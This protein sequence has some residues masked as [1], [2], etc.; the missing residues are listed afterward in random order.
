MN[1]FTA[2]TLSLT[3]LAS[4]DSALAFDSITETEKV[5]P[6]GGMSNDSAGWSIA[7]DGD[8]MAIGS[9]KDNTSDGGGDAGSVT[10]IDAAGNEHLL[11]ASNAGI[12]ENL[13]YSVDVRGNLLIAGA[14]LHPIATREGAA[15]IY[16]RNNNGNWVEEAQLVAPNGQWSDFFGCSVAISDTTAVVGA[17]LSDIEGPSSGTAWVF[18]YD[19]CCDWELVQ[20]LVPSSPTVKFGT[21]VAIG[22]ERIIVGSPR[23]NID[24]LS[25][26]SAYIFYLDRSDNDWEEEQRL[27]GSDTAAFDYFGYAVDLNVDGD[28]AVVGAI[29]NDAAAPNAGAAYVYRRNRSD[30]TWTEQEQLV[31]S[32]DEA[33]QKFGSSVSIDG[34]R[35][36]IGCYGYPDS[37]G[38]GY[39]Y[40]E[41]TEDGWVE[42]VKLVTTDGENGAR[43]G[44][45]AALS[46]SN[47]LL[48][49]PWQDSEAGAAYYYD[50][51]RSMQGGDLNFDGRIDIFDLLV[52]LRDWGECPDT[53]APCNG[54]SD[55]NELVDVL[56]LLAVLEAWN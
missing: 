32:G 7:M 56:D 45:K 42:V 41:T 49:A 16:R 1:T 15:Y 26:G 6:T 43:V 28:L 25:A 14:P 44:Y 21:S 2:I 3:C 40:E 18:E 9:P 54:D 33:W 10:V 35:A 38:H 4:I 22:D 52:V 39:L 29:Y 37:P 27:V 31:P 17:Y 19:G 20:R 23:D 11:T 24:G 46:G 36:A 53:P 12:Y 47:V 55:R 8:L 48:G 34:S 13:G 51:D 50:L 5:V 30:D